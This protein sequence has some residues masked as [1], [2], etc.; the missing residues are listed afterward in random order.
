MSD[1]TRKRVKD[2]TTVWLATRRETSPRQEP[3]RYPPPAFIGLFKGD[4][5][6]AARAKDIAR[7]RDNRA[8]H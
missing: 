6:L 8:T 1:T 5:D 2:N 4:N 3:T 7:G